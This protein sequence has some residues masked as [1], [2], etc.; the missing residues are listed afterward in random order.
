LP[1]GDVVEDPLEPVAPDEEALGMAGGT[2]VTRLAAEGDEESGSTFRAVDAD[3]AVL[4]EAT[5]EETR[6]DL[7]DAAVEA[8]VSP[9]ESLVVNMDETVVVILKETVEG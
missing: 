7:V 8:T 5:V 6:N 2:E 1:V 3:E 4:E 9:A